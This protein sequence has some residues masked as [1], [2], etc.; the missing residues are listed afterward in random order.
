VR[1]QDRRGGEKLKER[2]LKTQENHSW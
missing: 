2:I 1:K